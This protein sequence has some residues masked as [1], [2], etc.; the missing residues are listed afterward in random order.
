MAR[1][2]KYDYTDAMF[3]LEVEGY[4]RKGLSDAEIAKNISLSEGQFNR[5]KKQFP[6]LSQVLKKGRRPLNV[7]VENALFKRAT[8]FKV[9]SVVRKW[10][11]VDGEDGEPKNVELVSETETDVPPDTGAAMAWL[12]NRDPEQW[13]KQPEKKEVEHSGLIRVGYGENEGDQD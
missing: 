12:K 7:I 2:T 8:G 6:Q 9:K 11:V 4:A 1:K 3:L 5:V 13:N 10:I